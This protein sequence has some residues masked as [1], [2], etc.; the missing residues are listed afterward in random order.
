MKFRGHPLLITR[1]LTAIVAAQEAAKP[2]IKT[3]GY[4]VTDEAD[5]A[6]AGAVRQLSRFPMSA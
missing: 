4:V 6:S 1:S 2:A 3:A 5:N